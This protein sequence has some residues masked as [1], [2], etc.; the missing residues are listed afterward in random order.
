MCLWAMDAVEAHTGKKPEPPALFPEGL[1]PSIPDEDDDPHYDPEWSLD[2]DELD[3]GEPPDPFNG[4]ILDLPEVAP[5]PIIKGVA[6]ATKVFDG[7]GQT[8]GWPKGFK[9]LH[10]GPEAMDIVGLDF[11]KVEGSFAGIDIVSTPALVT[12]ATPMAAQDQG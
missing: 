9:S 1:I 12:R 2:D 7:K 8:V 5:V 4:S 10:N 3:I 11:G 6:V